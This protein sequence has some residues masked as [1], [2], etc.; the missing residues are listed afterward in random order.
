MIL[1]SWRLFRWC[2]GLKITRPH[3]DLAHGWRI[4][5]DLD[6]VLIWVAEVDREHWTLRADTVY[7]TRFDLDTLFAEPPFNFIDWK[8]RDEAKVG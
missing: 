5:A 7:W 1:K 8:D 6:E 2:H 4:A 3:G